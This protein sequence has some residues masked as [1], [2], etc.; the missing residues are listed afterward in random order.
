MRLS[1]KRSRIRSRIRIRISNPPQAL[2]Y[3]HATD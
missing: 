1:R 2:T 3:A